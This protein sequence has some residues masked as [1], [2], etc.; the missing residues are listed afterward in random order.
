MLNTILGMVR[1]AALLN[2]APCTVDMVEGNVAVVV[3]SDRTV[4]TVPS[5]LVGDESSVF[6]GTMESCTADYRGDNGAAIKL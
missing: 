1:L 4:A 3:C 2:S 5:Y 6:G